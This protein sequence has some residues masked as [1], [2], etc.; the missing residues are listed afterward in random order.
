MLPVS[1]MTPV[2]SNSGGY[3]A[4]ICAIT[5]F[6][7]TTGIRSAISDRQ[8]YAHAG[9]GA[10]QRHDPAAVISRAADG[11]DQ[12]DAWPGCSMKNSFSSRFHNTTSFA[13]IGA[14]G[15]GLGRSRVAT[16]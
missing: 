6:G 4:S 15:M 16:V 7:L 3:S 5:S 13:V 2:P 8:F 1:G 14:S 9:E 11:E 10:R 12:A